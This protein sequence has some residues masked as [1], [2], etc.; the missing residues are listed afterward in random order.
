MSSVMPSKRYD[1]GTG[2]FGKKYLA[3]IVLVAIHSILFGDAAI[4]DQRQ[5]V[6]RRQMENFRS[7]AATSRSLSF[8]NEIGIGLEIIE[9]KGWHWRLYLKHS[10]Q[11]YLNKSIMPLL[12]LLYQILIM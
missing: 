4:S 1:H 7:I 3:L 10:L 8:R 12:R 5:K 2:E 6:I 11:V 9:I